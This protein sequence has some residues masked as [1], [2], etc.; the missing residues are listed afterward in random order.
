MRTSKFWFLFVLP[1]LGLF[2]PVQS[3][4]LKF[5]ETP[6]LRLLY[7]DPTETYLVPHAARS[8]E[9]SL[10]SQRSI[11]DYDPFEKVTVL[12][13]DFSD[14][15][16]AGALP[17]PRNT[18]IVDIA[19]RALTFETAAPAE[20]LYTW[21]NHELVHLVT[22]EQTTAAD[23]RLRRLF[24]GKVQAISD[25]PETL[26]YQYLTTPR[27][28]SPRWYH[29]GMAVFTQT[30]MAGGLG[31][32]QGGYDEMVFRSMVR[33]GAHFF[34]PVGLVS[35]GT[36]VDF[37]VGVNAYLYGTRFLSYLAYTYSPEKL[38]SWV[39]RTEGSKRYYVSQFELVFGMPLNQAWQNWIEW[40]HEFQ[41]ANLDSVGQ[42]PVTPYSD[43]SK[44]PLGSVSRAFFD[45]ETNK[46]YAAFRYQGAVAH[47]GAI[48]LD[49][50]SIEKIEDIKGPMLFRVTSLAFDPDSKTLFYTSDNFAYRDLM[51]VNPATGE[52]K[53]LLRDARIGELVFN[54]TDRSIWG[55]RHLNGVV[56][57]VRI[58]YPYEEWNQIHTFP[59]G[60]MLY[61]MTFRL[62]DGCFQHRSE[63]CRGN[64]RFKYWK[65]I[66]CLRAISNRYRDLIVG[67]PFRRAL[68]F[69]PTANS[70]LGVRT[71]RAYRTYSDTKSRRA[72][73]RPSAMPKP[74]SSGRYPA[75]MAL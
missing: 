39:T 73:L 12:L 33:D 48:S 66:L 64:N 31:R 13:K 67:P 37:Q 4:D 34:S 59:Y 72:T 26:I 27:L 57:L 45:P 49:D 38:I 44:R 58:P 14:Y 61:D 53:M 74:V 3:E 46:L 28:A 71:I 10:R 5:L 75:K 7:F 8:F 18:V 51:S 29:E 16:N 20:R 63:T 36:M 60:T 2:Q 11:F 19:P 65:S 50:G 52:S 25:H 55:T 1:A 23:R 17:V 62:M 24:G 32:A 15:G 68:Y 6:D 54:K 30:W 9:N 21:M 69:R 22:T 47:I 56:T 35:S 70:S 43:L 40:E 41:R 42:Y